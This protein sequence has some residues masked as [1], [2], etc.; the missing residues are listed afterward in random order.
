MLHFAE[1]DLLPAPAMLQDP[2]KPG[3]LTH[4]NLAG[5]APQL[6]NKCVRSHRNLSCECAHRSLPGFNPVS[7]ARI[8]AQRVVP[9]YFALELVA[10][11][12]SID[13]FGDIVTEVA[14]I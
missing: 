11:V 8:K 14:M 9:E 5:I 10:D 4:R 1:N 6:F 13:Q 3:M 2:L 7:Q 12:F